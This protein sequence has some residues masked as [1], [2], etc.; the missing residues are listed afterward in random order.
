MSK[1]GT[2]RKYKKDFISYGMDKS[3][4]KDY[5]KA[6]RKGDMSDDDMEFHLNRQKDVYI[7]PSTDER[8][9]SERKIKL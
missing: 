4:A 1:L 3:L 9:I 6:Y 5:A 2:A 8:Q 7:K